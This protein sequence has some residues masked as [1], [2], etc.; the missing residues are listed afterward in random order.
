MYLFPWRQSILV[1]TETISTCFH[2]D[3]QSSDPKDCKQVGQCSDSKEVVYF[4][5]IKDNPSSNPSLSIDAS[6]CQQTSPNYSYM[7]LGMHPPNLWRD[8][9]S[10][11]LSLTFGGITL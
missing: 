3:N 9:V 5:D 11:C 4:K 8:S 6:N 1:S 2:G 10:L 7:A